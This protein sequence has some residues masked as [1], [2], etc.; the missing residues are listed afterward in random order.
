[1]SAIKSFYKTWFETQENKW[2][3]G[4]VGMIIITI[5]LAAVFNHEASAIEVVD[6]KELAQLTQSVLT[7]KPGGEWRE[8]TGSGSESG[9]T[10]ERDSTEVTIEIS[11]E[12][13]KGISCTLSWTDEPSSYFQGEN[14][15]DE[16]KVEIIAPNDETLA[17]SDLSTSGSISAGATLPNYEETDDFTTNYVGPWVIRVTAGDC[18]DDSSRLGFRQTADNGNDWE[19]EYTYHYME[20]VENPETQ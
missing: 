19:L 11:Q 7:G 9:H 20:F 18:G 13:L 15:P 4:L 17:E 16:F 14:A 1:M 5:M 10:N 8:A 12:T 6:E 3:T 2:K